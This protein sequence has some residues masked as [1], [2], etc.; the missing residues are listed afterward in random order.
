MNKQNHPHVNSSIQTIDSSQ[1]N[2]IL[3]NSNPA[4]LAQSSRFTLNHTL[5]S[6]P[7]QE[8]IMAV[9]S[10]VVANAQQPSLSTNNPA[11]VL[12]PLFDP[13]IVF[14]SNHGVPHSLQYDSFLQLLD[15]DKRPFLHSDPQLA[16]LA[17]TSSACNSPSPST[18]Q[19]PS[20]AMHLPSHHQ[21]SSN[22][23]VTTPVTAVGDLLAATLQL[24][25]HLFPPHPPAQI[26]LP[27]LSSASNG[28][29][30]HPLLTSSIQPQATVTGARL[31]F[32]LQSASVSPTDAN[33]NYVTI[34]PHT[35]Q[36]AP[37]TIGN[38]QSV[39][40]QSKPQPPPEDPILKKKRR[41]SVACDDCNKRKVRCDGSKP[42]CSQC[43]RQNIECT[44]ERGLRKKRL[45]STSSMKSDTSIDSFISS[46]YYCDSQNNLDG[47]SMQQIPFGTRMNGVDHE[48]A[49]IAMATTC[50]LSS[51]DHALTLLYFKTFHQCCPMIHERTF[52]DNI[53]KQPMILVKSMCAIAVLYSC[54][55]TDPASIDPA[56]P[57]DTL[58]E[59]SRIYYEQAKELI[60]EEL[61]RPSIEAI[62]A[63]LMLAIYSAGSGKPSATAHFS[64]VA[65]QMAV[66]LKL[67]LESYDHPDLM[68]AKMSFI[69]KEFRRYVWWLLVSVDSC[70]GALDNYKAVLGPSQYHIYL[71][72]QNEVYQSFTHDMP[73]LEV[74]STYKTF[75]E[76][77][78]IPLEKA[79]L[80][81]LF[82]CELFQNPD[83][84]QV[85]INRLFSRVVKL[86]Q[87]HD[88][89]SMPFEHVFL[90]GAKKLEPFSEDTASSVPE[91]V[92][93]LMAGYCALT[94]EIEDFFSVVP[95]SLHP[96]AIVVPNTLRPDPCWRM[97][98]AL[99]IFYTS[100]IM[101]YRPI[102]LQF[103]KHSTPCAD[104]Q[105]YRFCRDASDTMT[106]LLSKALAVNP[107]MLYFS[108][109]TAFC[110]LQCGIIHSLSG[111]IEG[112][113]SMAKWESMTIQMRALQGF[114]KFWKSAKRVKDI[115]GALMDKVKG[116]AESTES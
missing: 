8:D 104:S 73:D 82:S 113:S 100:Q 101:L 23:N 79:S 87:E 50:S 44:F 90:F 22:A 42:A 84:Y 1:P 75:F 96:H 91:S 6:A 103:M 53:K 30:P 3:M 45:N 81:D 68:N 36:T 43:L 28:F 39:H 17:N 29:N 33:D 62:A 41:I 19:L 20:S 108:P 116:C 4:A 26:Y 37:S 67:N 114:S 86:M 72:I 10:N 95:S 112:T 80:Q 58:S 13:S 18:I 61:D 74:P 111:D 93:N 102:L 97:I 99:L 38:G 31:S 107:D 69:D 16:A 59:K 27:A 40:V 14:S 32:S 64:N 51:E 11:S 109:F 65:I 15:F 60:D 2:H 77:N 25:M 54:I 55:Q 56:L 88:V 106:M 94:T 12:T 66:L 78:R 98:L 110:T 76:T 89:S 115:F 49:E 63:L 92:R 83:A 46:H 24:D 35:H 70:V 34:V 57:N 105:A 52:L 47:L 48:S 9:L 5:Q 21:V 71:P 7:R 85:F